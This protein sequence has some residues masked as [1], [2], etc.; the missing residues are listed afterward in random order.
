MLTVAHPASHA[1]A[2]KRRKYRWHPHIHMARDHYKQTQSVLVGMYDKYRSMLLERCEAATSDKIVSLW[3]HQNYVVVKAMD[4][5]VLPRSMCVWFEN[6]SNTTS[7]VQVTHQN[8]TLLVVEH[9]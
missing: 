8:C 3:L 9:A 6:I 5:Y 1:A 7:V 4:M 2:S